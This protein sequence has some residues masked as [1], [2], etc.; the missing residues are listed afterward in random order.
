LPDSVAVL[1]EREYRLL[2]GAQAVSLLG[3]GMI[4]VALA[5]AVIGLGGGAPEIGLVFTLRAVAL[6]ATL[7]AGGVVGDRLPRRAV[8]ISADL[9]RVVS[10]GALAVALIAGAP[11]FWVIGAL[12]AV[13]SV[14]TGFFNPTSTAFLPAVVS[15]ARLQQA[16]ALRGLVNSIGRIGGPSL[17]G[18][19]VVT[20]GAGWALAFD[21]STFAISAALL[22]RI[23]VS[24]HPEP[25]R[26]SFVADLKEGWDA[27]R[28][29]TWLWSFVAWF[30]FGNLLYGCWAIV[31]PLVAERDLGGAGP[32]GLII[33]ASGAGGVV[34]G[35]LALRAHP[36]RPLLFAACGLSILFV[37]LALLAL[38]LP[39]VLIA[40]GA[41]VSEVGLVLGLS[42]WESTLQRHVPAATLSRVSAYDWFGSLAFLPVGLALWGPIADA[43][44]YDSALWL[45]FGLHVASVIPLLAVREIRRLPAFPPAT[46]TAATA[47]AADSTSST[48]PRPP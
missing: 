17:A 23:H 33:A 43:I 41:V 35:L 28:S 26:K 9:A 37:P 15:P 3:D 38:G 24:D 14:A 7:L 29:R 45:A 25:A 4:N 48:G 20:A 1:R 13:T 2:F 31:G 42:V 5:F 19:L 44:G 10:Q 16:N 46:A 47:A 39:A 40:A 18:L 34:G 32:W 12:S 36:R 22:S 8:L 27:F 6:V 11:A 30:S 21:A